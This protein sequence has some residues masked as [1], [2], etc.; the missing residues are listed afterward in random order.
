MTEPTLFA[1]IT[2][3]SSGIGKE[4]AIAFAARGVTV[5][6]TARRT[7][8]LA[9][10][11]SKYTNIEALALELGNPDGD[12]QC[13]ERLKDAVSERTGG[14]LDFLVNNAGTHYASTALDAEMSEVEHL[15]RINVIA[16]MQMCQVFMP[17]LRCSKRGRIVQIGSV[18]R[19]VPMVWQAAYNASKAAL[20][21]YSNTLRLVG[22]AFDY[23]Y[24]SIPHS[25]SVL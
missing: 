25:P 5:L 15:F 12:K 16:V 14:R 24:N 22:L 20:S 2:G 17:L 13:I 7:E 4:L 11:T 23:D 6:A 8:S 3:C 18:T 21:Q 19:D 9:D 10:L 1:L